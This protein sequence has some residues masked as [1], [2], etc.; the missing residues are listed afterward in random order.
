MN[1]IL[2]IIL[3]V[4]FTYSSGAMALEFNCKIETPAAKHWPREAHIKLQ[5]SSIFYVNGYKLHDAD[6]NWDYTYAYGKKYFEEHYILWSFHSLNKRLFVQKFIKN[7]SWF[8]S[9]EHL[10]TDGYFCEL[11]S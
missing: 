2:P 1:K 10:Y 3:V 4:L 9:D 6:I 7:N 5:G 11:R 8:G